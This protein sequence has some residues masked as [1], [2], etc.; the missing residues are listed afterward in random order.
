MKRSFSIN[1]LVMVFLPVMLI[2]SA[3]LLA[4]RMAGAS[5]VNQ[6]TAVD[7]FYANLARDPEGMAAVGNARSR[8]LSLSRDPSAQPWKDVLENPFYGLYNDKVKKLFGGDEQVAK[9]NVVEFVFCLESILYT[10]DSETQRENIA[11]F[12]ASAAVQKILGNDHLVNELCDYLEGTKKNVPGSVKQ[13]LSALAGLA[14]GDQSW[15]AS[16]NFINLQK[17]LRAIDWSIGR[18]VSAAERV[19]SQIDPGYKGDYALIKA[20]MISVSGKK[21][22]P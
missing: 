7:I 19:G 16:N 20:Y 17:K 22:R 11:N 9:Q 15:R 13:D 4:P 3:V 18:L 1:R 8:L 6:S 10:T 14:S 12:R 2:F 21:G 5:M